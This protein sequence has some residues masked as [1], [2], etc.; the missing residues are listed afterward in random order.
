MNKFWLMLGK[1]FMPELKLMLMKTVKRLFF[2]ED[3]LVNI[4]PLY[5]ESYNFILLGRV[6]V[7]SG[8]LVFT[9]VYWAYGLYHYMQY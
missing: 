1:I 8:I 3:S 2:G 5:I 6:V 7:P 4:I 9:A